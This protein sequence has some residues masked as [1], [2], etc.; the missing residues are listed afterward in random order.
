MGSKNEQGERAKGGEGAPRSS[1][2]GARPAEGPAPLAAARPSSLSSQGA[3]ACQVPGL[4][5]RPPTCCV[6]G[7]LSPPNATF[8]SLTYTGPCRSA[9]QGPPGRRSRRPAARAAG[10]GFDQP[11]SGARTHLHTRLRNE[12]NQTNCRGAIGKRLGSDSRA[13]VEQA[14]GTSAGR[15]GPGSGRERDALKTALGLG[16]QGQAP[17]GMLGRHCSSKGL[18]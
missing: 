2:R 1:P 10:S 13:R 3:I 18:L 16:E 15:R 6:P 14:A 5:A 12:Q 8:G 17:Q 11:D 7:A 9:K 4:R